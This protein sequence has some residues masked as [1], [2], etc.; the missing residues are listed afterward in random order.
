MFGEPTFLDMFCEH[1]SP[2]MTMVAAAFDE[3]PLAFF[4]GSTDS[5][6]FVT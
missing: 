3:R 4:G 2:P 6:C 1:R 5:N